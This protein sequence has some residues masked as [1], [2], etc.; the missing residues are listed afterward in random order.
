MIANLANSLRFTAFCLAI[1]V[2]MSSAQPAEASVEIFE[3]RDVPV[4]ATAASAAEARDTALAQGQREAFYR[5]LYR[6]TLKEHHA[7]IPNLDAGTISTYVRDFSVSGEKT[8][9]V[10]YLARLHVRFKE[11]DVRSLLNE[12]GLPFA[13]TPSKPALVL[14]V[15]KRGAQAVLWRDPNPWRQAWAAVPMPN[16]PVPLMLPVGDLDDIGLVTVQQALGIDPNALS[17]IAAR[18]EAGAAIVVR[19]DLAAIGAPHLELLITRAAL[20]GET[21]T[22]AARVEAGT[23]ET[24]DTVLKRAA[25][26]AIDLIEEDWKRQNLMNFDQGGILA[27]SVPIRSLE[28]W[29]DIR[30]RI[31]EI[32]VIDRTDLILLSREEALL[33]IHFIGTT[34]QLSRALAQIDLNLSEQQGVWSLTS[35]P[36]QGAAIVQP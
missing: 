20:T 3:V 8:S 28:H 16:A 12:F 32:A 18:Y 30:R 25:S 22:V 5:L 34:S 1:A 11:R 14:P 29:L 4:D 6:L 19:A 35:Q 27:V 24:V 26:I 2:A 15:L 21:T 31:G 10:R 33:N 17:T 7:L 9:D 36:A 13:E 23:G